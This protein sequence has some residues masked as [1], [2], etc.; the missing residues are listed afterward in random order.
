MTN[1]LVLTGLAN[2]RL[3]GDPE[4]IDRELF[5]HHAETLGLGFSAWADQRILR[6]VD[7]GAGFN[8]RMTRHPGATTE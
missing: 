4:V 5:H 7:S 6:A 8:S 2:F 1:A 3:V